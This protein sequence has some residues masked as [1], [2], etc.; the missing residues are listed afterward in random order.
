LLGSKK[1]PERIT[2]DIQTAIL[3]VKKST[4]IKISLFIFLGR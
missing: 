4:V 1:L 2:N 3:K